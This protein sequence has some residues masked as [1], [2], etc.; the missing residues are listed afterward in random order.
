MI[1]LRQA[2]SFPLLENMLHTYG[3][4]TN[5]Q[6]AHVSEPLTGIVRAELML[7]WYHNG[8]LLVPMSAAAVDYYYWHLSELLL[9]L[10]L[11]A[12]GLLLGTG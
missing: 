8:L 7:C 1:D 10:E 4:F 9:G 12:C 5:K 2:I 3:M 11:V 6:Y